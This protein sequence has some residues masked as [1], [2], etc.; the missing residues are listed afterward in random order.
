MYFQ[1]WN[2]SV[3][4][5][6][7]VTMNDLA[8]IVLNFLK[9]SAARADHHSCGGIKGSDLAITFMICTRMP[10]NRISTIDKERI[11]A[12]YERN[13]DCTETAWHLNIAQG[14]AYAIIRRYQRFG[15]A[16]RPHHAFKEGGYNAVAFREFLEECSRLLVNHE[17]VFIFDNAP[18]HNSAATAHLQPNRSYRFEPPYSP[19]LNICEGSFSIWKASF[20]RHMAEVCHHLLLQ[21]HQERLA[22]MMQLAEQAIA[23]VTHEKT[24]RL[25]QHTLTLIPACLAKEDIH[26][27]WYV[28]M[29]LFFKFSYFFHT[30]HVNKFFRNWNFLRLLRNC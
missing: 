14:T 19:F 21:G 8:W 6:A 5:Y 29:I 7:L 18:S 11:I 26:H 1:V 10:R 17:V 20:K 4:K 30:V 22:T 16:A 27:E 15:V 28:H 3:Q 23:D 13:D 12:A 2:I 25:Y 24:R 9:S